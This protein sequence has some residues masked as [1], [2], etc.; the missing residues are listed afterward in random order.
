MSNCIFLQ[1]N[2]PT[3]A[4]FSYSGAAQSYVIPADVTYIKI[5]MAGAAGSANGNGGYGARIQAVIPV[6]TGTTLNFYI[7][8]AGY[9]FNGGGTVVGGGGAGGGAT[10]IRIGGNLLSNRV[11]VAGAGGGG[12][13]YAC[14]SS[15]WIAN[16]GH[17]GTLVG[18]DGMSCNVNNQGSGGTQTSGGSGGAGGGSPGSLGQGGNGLSP[19]GGGGGGGYYGGGGGYNSGGGGGSSYVAPAYYGNTIVTA[20]YNTGNGYVK[21]AILKAGNRFKHCILL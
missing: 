11:L 18:I 19:F 8:G 2:N 16:G 14:T 6:L 21:I 4:S 20:G 3:T 9:T 10:D 1:V 5:D 17:G 12:T 13:A 7:G 15:S